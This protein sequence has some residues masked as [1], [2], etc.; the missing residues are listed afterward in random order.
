VARPGRLLLVALAL[1]ALVVLALATGASAHQKVTIEEGEGFLEQL[2][3]N[4]VIHGDDRPDLVTVIYDP[5]LDEFLIGH[6]IEDPIPEGCYR[7]SEEPFH[8]LH[9]P[10]RLITG[11]VFVY[12]GVGNDRVV[13]TAKVKDIVESV[14]AFLGGGNDS[15]EGDEEDDEVDEEEGNDQART[16]GGADMVK[17][18]PGSD[19]A[20]GGPG[21]DRLLGGPNADW[22]FGGPGG[23]FLA[24]GP[25]ADHCLGGPGKERVSGCE[26]GFRY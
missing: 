9:C 17:G 8:I 20:R 2:G 1:V 7:D 23:D 11:R 16:G 13:I 21:P 14:K 26:V 15:F 25:S 5:V 18:G 3:T 12:T 6:D 24:G 22:L 4:L 19:K 10:R